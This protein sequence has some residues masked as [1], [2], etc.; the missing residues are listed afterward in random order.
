MS[1]ENQF[2]SNQ[3]EMW[4]KVL[5]LP[6]GGC[7]AEPPSGHRWH[8]PQVPDSSSQAASGREDCQEPAAYLLGNWF[9][10]SLIRL[11]SEL[12]PWMKIA[13]GKVNLGKVC[14]CLFV[15]PLPMFPDDSNCETGSFFFCKI[16]QLQSLSKHTTFFKLFANAKSYFWK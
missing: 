13:L 5:H 16:I 2:H 12:S 15:F 10:L 11:K 7:T 14:S 9:S 4:L 6:A 3:G 8:L 1:R